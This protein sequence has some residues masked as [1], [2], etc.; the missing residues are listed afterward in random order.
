MNE[1][2][3]TGQ[4]LIIGRRGTATVEPLAPC[5]YGVRWRGTLHTFATK[6]DALKY[7]RDIVR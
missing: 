6:A 3:T 2:E 5:G 7:A 4:G 1:E